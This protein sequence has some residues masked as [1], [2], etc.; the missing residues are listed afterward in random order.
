MPKTLVRT[1]RVCQCTDDRACPGG[2][3]WAEADLCTACVPPMDHCDR[4][5]PQHRAA[6]GRGWQAHKAGK[7]RKTCPY[8]AGA[9]AVVGR[10]RH[11]PTGERG[12]AK[13]WLAGWD[14]YARQA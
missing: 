10:G 12:Y 14:F 8:D 6:W 7:A 11:I 2:C 4:S 3:A 9:T 1:C 5:T 13:A